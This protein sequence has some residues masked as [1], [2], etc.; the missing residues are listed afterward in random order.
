MTPAGVSATF[1]IL[2]AAT[3]PPASAQSSPEPPPVDTIVARY[4]E[5]IGGLE[6]IRAIRTLEYV[7]GRY[8]E[9]DFQGSGNARMAFRRPY[10]RVVGNPADE[11]SYLEGFDGGAWEWYPDPGITIRTVGPA[12]GATRRGSDFEGRLVDY[13]AKGSEVSLAGTAT[14]DGRPAYRLSLITRD[15]F[16]RDYFVDA[17]SWL[18]VAERYVAPV[19]AFGTPV[20]SETRIGDYRPVAGVLLAHRFRET[21]VGTGRL[22]NEMQWGSIEAGKDLPLHH[23]S[24]PARPRSPLQRMLQALYSARTDTQAALWTYE[25]FRRG[26]PDIDPALGVEWVAYQMLKMGDATDTAI[27]LLEAN[28]R[29]HPQSAS[30]AFSLGRA[31]ETAGFE[32]TARDY[33]RRALALDPADRRAGEALARMDER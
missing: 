15:G 10:Y 4:I 19:H 7:E 29:A 12:A 8:R 9:G 17:D 16:R 11:G 24:P 5:A 31:F 3:A 14:Y 30:A 25:E 6:A 2:V 22:L 18:I 28:G 13:R 27:R 26:Y 21:E 32:D 1:L 23:F 33:Y 20:A